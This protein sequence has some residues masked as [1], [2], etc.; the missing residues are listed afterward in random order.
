M[1]RT[2]IILASTSPRRKEL[3]SQAQ[4]PFVAQSPKN[5]NEILS[6]GLS[7]EAAIKNLAYQKAHSLVTDNPGVL[8]LGADTLVKIDNQVLGKPKDEQEAFD[9]LKQLSGRTHE[10]ITGVA[11]VKDAFS[12]CFHSTTLVHF[13]QMS[14]EEIYEYIDSKEVFN[15]AGSYA[16]QGFGARYVKALEGDYYT[17]MGLPINKVYRSYQAYLNNQLF[18]L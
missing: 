6:E 1:K 9:M 4:I 13:H 5:G 2:P 11:F 3:L 10:V 14:D 18:S 16:I 7:F 12:H 17:V 8:I 15:K